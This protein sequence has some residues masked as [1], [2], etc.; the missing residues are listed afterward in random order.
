M[1]PRCLSLTA[2]CVVH[3]PTHTRRHNEKCRLSKSQLRSCF[4]PLPIIVSWRCFYDFSFNVLWLKMRLFITDIS[5]SLLAPPFASTMHSHLF[6]I[7]STN[8]FRKIRSAS[9][10]GS[11]SD[12]FNY[13]IFA[14]RCGISIPSVLFSIKGWNKYL[15]KRNVN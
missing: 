11:L 4:G 5:A 9:F 14:C 2:L 1:V 15:A 10:C 8:A 12:K 13:S 6:I 7:I 3:T